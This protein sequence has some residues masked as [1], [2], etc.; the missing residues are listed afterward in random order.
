MPIGGIPTEWDI[1]VHYYSDYLS[2][3]EQFLENEAR[4]LDERYDAEA[5]KIIT[6]GKNK[7]RTSRSEHTLSPQLNEIELELDALADSLGERRRELEDIFSNILRRSFFVAIYSLIEAQLNAICHDQ[8][9][10]KGLESSVEDLTEPDKGIGRARKYLVNEARIRFP[11]S[12]EW[13][14]L[15]GYQKLRNCIIH[16][17]GRLGSGHKN[18]ER[19][20]KYLKEEF[21]PQHYPKLEWKQFDDEIIF[22]KGFCEE[23]LQVSRRFFTK[24]FAAL[25]S[26]EEG[27]F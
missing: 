24:L 18:H 7:K 1:R 12:P 16:N 9:R 4:T 5:Q 23:V 10:A 8:E 26:E 14:K 15:R 11:D 21:I 19:A 27:D 3:L 6:E 2:S 22:H 17:E 20:R 25:R 13:N